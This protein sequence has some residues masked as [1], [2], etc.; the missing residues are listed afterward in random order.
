VEFTRPKKYPIEINITPLIDMVFMLL[1]FFLLTSHLIGENTIDV[2][3][4]KAKSSVSHT[5]NS[6]HVSITRGGNIFVGKIPVQKNDL[7]FV[8]KRRYKIKESKLVVLRADK[9]IRLDKAV[10]IMDLIRL[11]GAEKIVLATKIPTK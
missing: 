4:P 8:L 6:I 2:K 9:D 10:E 11:S 1:V 5:Q 3:L 7:I